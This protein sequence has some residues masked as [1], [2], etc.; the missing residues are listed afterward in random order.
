MVTKPPSSDT[1]WSLESNTSTKGVSVSHLSCLSSHVMC[2][3]CVLLETG[4]KV[5]C[6]IFSRYDAS[7]GFACVNAEQPGGNRCQDYKVRFTCP[8]AFCSVWTGT[9][10]VHMFILTGPEE[11]PRTE[12]TLFVWCNTACINRVLVELV[13]WHLW[14]SEI[15]HLPKNW[16]E[17]RHSLENNGL[18]HFWQNVCVC[19]N[20]EHINTFIHRHV[21]KLTF[22]TKVNESK[23]RFKMCWRT[24]DEGRGDLV[25]PQSGRS[26]WGWAW[27]G[28]RETGI[29]FHRVDLICCLLAVIRVPTTSDCRASCVCVRVRVTGR[30]YGQ[31]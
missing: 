4:K 14:R 15:K 30:V 3:C 18:R 26:I 1:W 29:Q 25:N 5:P 8:L 17:P 13:F 20:D 21:A 11:D 28:R 6:L 12:V 23:C 31:W 27:L 24:F 2:A 19:F 9:T 22:H 7:R 16:S 10:C